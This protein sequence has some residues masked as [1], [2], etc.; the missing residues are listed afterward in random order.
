MESSGSEPGEP[1]ELA[2]DSD[3]TAIGGKSVENARCQSD[4]TDEEEDRGGNGDATKQTDTH[5]LRSRSIRPTGM[6][7]QTTF[8]HRNALK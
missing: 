5:S 7:R 2:M 1:G 4:T 8:L 3:M 6:A